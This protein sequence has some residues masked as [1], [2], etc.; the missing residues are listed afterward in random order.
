[1]N[2]AKTYKADMMQSSLQGQLR[3]F[4]IT[5]PQNTEHNYNT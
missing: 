3:S 4:R 2:L 1:M 5:V